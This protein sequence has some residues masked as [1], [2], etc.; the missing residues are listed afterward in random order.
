MCVHYTCLCI[1]EQVTLKTSVSA[2]TI[3][4]CWCDFNILDHD[5][6]SYVLVY[7]VYYIHYT[8]LHTIDHIAGVLRMEPLT[9]KRP[10]TVACS[11]DGLFS[12]SRPWPFPPP[13]QFRRFWDQ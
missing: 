4:C 6:S 7:L 12:G 5:N 3:N 2:V 11:A 13:F 1:Y 8:H 10:W 9:A